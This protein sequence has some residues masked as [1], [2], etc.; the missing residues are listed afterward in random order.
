MKNRQITAL[1]VAGLLSEI[2][3]GVLL[4]VLGAVTGMMYSDLLIFVLIGFGL[5]LG[6]GIIQALITRKAWTL[7]A[8]MQMFNIVTQIIPM[9]LAIC[10]LIA[11]PMLILFGVIGSGIGLVSVVSLSVGI[12]LTTVFC[13]IFTV[14]TR[15]KK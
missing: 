8:S 6:F 11:T 2:G 3:C 12:I 14:I 15:K 4:I 1:T 5:S 13:K 10:C 7:H 9:T